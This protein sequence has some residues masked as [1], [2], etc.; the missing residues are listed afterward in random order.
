MQNP[1]VISILGRLDRGER[2]SGEETLQW[3]RAGIAPQLASALSQ[4]PPERRQKFAR[5]AIDLLTD[6]GRPVIPAAG[7]EPDRLGPIVNKPAVVAYLVGALETGDADLRDEIG[8]VLSEQVPGPLL[9]PNAASIFESLRKYPGTSGGVLILGRIGSP[10]ARQL[11][12]EVE[13]LRLTSA[14]NT[15]IALARLG[16]AAAE[17]R[18]I[19]AYH[20]ASEV[21]AKGDQAL[22]VG[23]IATRNAILTLARDFRT[24]EFYFWH[25]RSRRSLRVHL[26]EG[27]HRAFLSEPM[28]WKPYY[29]P[30]SD[31]YYERI[32]AWLVSHLQITW[33]HP[34]PPFLYEEDAP[35]PAVRP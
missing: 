3:S 19:D 21:S 16:D 35:L 5:P 32:E 8:A 33:N 7:G 25:M 23:Y 26:I 12:E 11:I 14:E 10:Q 1:T 28:F 34:R 2:F 30:Q 22:R 29:K 4:L 13:P 20:S 27:L 18:V 9:R 17:T 15:E 31:V 6:L 24:P